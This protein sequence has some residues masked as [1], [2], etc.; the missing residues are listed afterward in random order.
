[1]ASS[2]WHVPANRGSRDREP[3]HVPCH[4]ARHQCISSLFANAQSKIHI[5]T[6]GSRNWKTSHF[7]FDLL[8]Q[9]TSMI[10]ND[11]TWYFLVTKNA[12]HGNTKLWVW[13]QYLTKSEVT[14]RTPDHGMHPGAITKFCNINTWTHRQ[15]SQP[16]FQVCAW[17]QNNH[18]G[19][20]APEKMSIR[21]RS[22]LKTDTPNRLKPSLARRAGGAKYLGFSRQRFA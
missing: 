15:D 18:T 1:M 10:Q 21:I 9:T 20:G 2:P 17:T 13:W 12:F 5:A 6:N 14:L 8:Y 4:S 16:H 22:T 3:I 19:Q 11:S 7:F